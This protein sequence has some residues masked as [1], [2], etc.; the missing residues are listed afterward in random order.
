MTAIALVGTLLAGGLAATPAY[1]ESKYPS[2]DDIKQAKKNESNTKSEIDKVKDLISSLTDDYLAAEADAETKLSD[3]NDA[4]DAYS[5]GLVKYQ[6]LTKQAAAAKAAAEESKKQAGALVAQMYRSN[7]T[8]VSMQLLLSGGSEAQDLLY[9][10]SALGQITDTNYE[11]YQAAIN[12]SNLAD[13]LAR[14]AQAASDALA[15][16]ESTAKTKYAEAEAAQEAADTALQEQKDNQ[17]RLYSQ[18]A[19]L[20]DTTAALVK[21]REDGIK[22]AKEEAAKKAAAARKAAAE[23]R[24][25]AAEAA[26]NGDDSSGGD[27]GTDAPTSSGSWVTPTYGYISSGYGYRAAYTSNGFHNGVDIANSCGTPIYAAASGTVVFAGTE[28]Y[29]AQDIVIKHKNSV[30]TEYAHM[31]VGHLFVSVG[32]TVTKGQHIADMGKTGIATGCHLHFSVYL[33]SNWTLGM[34]GTHYNTTNPYTFMRKHGVT[35]GVG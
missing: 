13:S 9:K 10:L 35:L 18:L 22:K 8:D 29:G 16:L 3:Y 20:E 31:M 34:M 25:K 15:E 19:Q 21:E 27:S 4:L 24:R 7:G 5:V 17:D 33:T 26:A 12:D 28:P 30:Y 1:A 2:W 14:D 6:K 32:D 23:A 11:I